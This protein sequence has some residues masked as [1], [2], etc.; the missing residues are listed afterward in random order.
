MSITNVNSEDEG[1]YT[2]TVTTEL[3]QDSASARLTVQG[4][5]LLYAHLHTS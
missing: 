4:K 2:C 3:D 1:T 5:E